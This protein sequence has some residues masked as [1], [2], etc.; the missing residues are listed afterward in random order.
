MPVVRAGEPQVVGG[1]SLDRP[2]RWVH[3]SDLPDVAELLVGGELM[4]TT[5][6]ALTGGDEST[7]AYLR[8]LAAAG[9][10]GL[11][12]ELGEAVPELPRVVVELADEL[13]LPVVALHRVTRFV[14][15]TEAVHRIIV[16]DQYAELEFA[17][18]VH[19]T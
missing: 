5:G 11:V 4:L 1:G 7:V 3:V 9:V 14:E 13:G 10:A 6:L 2:V 18:T 17:R 19:E 15:I 16:A 12:V 8:S